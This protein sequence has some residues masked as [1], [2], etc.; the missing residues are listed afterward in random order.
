MSEAFPFTNS[1]ELNEWHQGITMANRNNIFCHCRSCRYEWVDSLYKAVCQK[2]GSQDV[3][4]ISC[5]QFPDD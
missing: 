1:A 3:E 2:C 5:W 4:R